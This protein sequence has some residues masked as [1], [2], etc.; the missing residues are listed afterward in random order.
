VTHVS[1]GRRP[2]HNRRVRGRSRL[3]VGG[4]ALAS[5][6]AFVLGSSAGS[7]GAGAPQETTSWKVAFVLEYSPARVFVVHA[8]GSGRHRTTLPGLPYPSPNGRRL[9]FAV[10]G[11]WPSRLYVADRDGRGRQPILR[12][13]YYASC[14]DPVWSPDSR[15]LLYTTDCDVDFETI[16]VVNADGSGRKMLTRKWSQNPAWSPNGRTIVFTSVARNAPPF[17]LYLMD[18]GGRGRRRVPGRYPDPEPT[19]NASSG[20][21]WSRDG[22]R[23]FFL[24]YQEDELRVINRAGSVSRNLTPTLAKVRDFDLSPDGRKLVLTAPGTP[25][26]GWEIYTVNVDGSGL[27]QLTENR[28]HDVEPTWSPDGQ[29]I[30]FES[31]RDG[32]SEIYV[33]NADGSEQIN[34]SRDPRDEQQPV[35]LPSGSRL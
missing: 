14:L 27:R 1:E 24:T 29:K 22:R 3:C 35:W 16:G 20:P 11:A 8:D 19:P 28:A 26:R 34:V 25:D 32:N 12:E 30:A 9:A 6:A 4:A 13:K 18:E 10:A 31:T 7:S 23:I 17:R 2:R 15:K 21:T 5:S 33:M